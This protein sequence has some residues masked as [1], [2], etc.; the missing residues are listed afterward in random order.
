MDGHSIM[1]DPMSCRRCGKMVNPFQLTFLEHQKWVYPGFNLAT[2]LC[3]TCGQEVSKEA[4]K[5]A[6]SSRLEAVRGTLD[7]HLSRAGIPP[8]YRKCTFED[9][10]PPTRQI[11]HVMAAC[12]DYAR[13]PRGVLFL[14]GP[15]G[16]GKTH[17]AAA[18]ARELILQGR[19]V[20]FVYV[21]K[22]LIQIRRAFQEENKGD[23]LAMISRYAEEI[24]YLVLDDIGA[25]KTTDWVRQTLDLI[26]YERD[27]HELSTVITS[28]L[29]LDEIAEKID[30]RISSRLA[31]MGKILPLIG[32]DY[33]ISSGKKGGG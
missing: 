3:E 23:E 27:T 21:P 7:Q 10:L 6:L 32:P 31:G 22:L 29:S 11:K 5:E 33:R 14:F 4:E 9:F 20:E 18:I 15:Y 12:Q 28:N 24:P 26:F 1:P 16:T 2:C 25:E 30:P 13:E 19:K 8:K 17:L